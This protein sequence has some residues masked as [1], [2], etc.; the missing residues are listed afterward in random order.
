MVGV[1]W[2]VVTPLTACPAAGI[3]RYNPTI[4]IV[5]IAEARLRFAQEANSKRLSR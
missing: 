3:I 5:E 1:I 2:D 4:D